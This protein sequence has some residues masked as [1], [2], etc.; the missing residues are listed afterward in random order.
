MLKDLRIIDCLEHVASNN[1][2][3]AATLSLHNTSLSDQIDCN[4]MINTVDADVHSLGRGCILMPRA[5]TLEFC[6]FSTTDTNVGEQNFALLSTDWKEL[7]IV[8]DALPVPLNT[9]DPSRLWAK[10]MKGEEIDQDQVFYLCTPGR[11]SLLQRAHWEIGPMGMP[12]ISGR[13]NIVLYERER[14]EAMINP[15]FD[16][17]VRGFLHELLPRPSWIE[18]PQCHLD[19]G[20]QV[21]LPDLG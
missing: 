14:E 5:G 8:L 2:M 11:T 3:L 21:V 19:P 18:V 15:T 1:Q 10:H 7:P 4:P 6:M 17:S 12:M 16:Y 9:V 20:V 13:K